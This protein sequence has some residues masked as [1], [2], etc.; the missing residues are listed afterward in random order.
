M[1]R[2]RTIALLLLM[3]V[4]GGVLLGGGYVNDG[5]VEAVFPDQNA[6]GASAGSGGP[7][8][9]SATTD[10]PANATSRASPAD[11]SIGFVEVSDE[12]G[13]NYTKPHA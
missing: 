11:Q 12:V 10:T 3:L 1:L 7:S 9:T 2:R 5:T 6:D 13:F 8:T 4:S